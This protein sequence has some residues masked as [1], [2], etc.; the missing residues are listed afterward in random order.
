MHIVS[1]VSH[2]HSVD[3]I[4]FIYSLQS[5]VPGSWKLLEDHIHS[6]KMTAVYTDYNCSIRTLN[7]I[8]ILS[9][10]IWPNILIEVASM[11]ISHDCGG[12]GILV[13]VGYIKREASG[14]T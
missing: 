13:A 4:T 10:T 9:V 11:F 8:Y 1:H 14:G 7:C 3:A 12:R 6:E 2:W 5:N